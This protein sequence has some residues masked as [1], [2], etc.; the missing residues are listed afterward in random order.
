MANNRHPRRITPQV[1]MAAFD[2]DD[3]AAV[4]DDVRSE[5]LEA[6]VEADLD[7]AV[8]ALMVD[9][10]VVVFG[11]V[12]RTILSGPDLSLFLTAYYT[13]AAD[14]FQ[15]LGDF[16]ERFGT[17]V[18]AALKRDNCYIAALR[19]AHPGADHWRSFREPRP[20]ANELLAR[21]V[22]ASPTFL[23][24]GGAPAYMGHTSDN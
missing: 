5:V 4:P 8:A 20:S 14:P 12:G 15:S 19:D 17:E 22:G 7:A 16:V 11:W 6:A 9:G 10:R 23:P 3:L 24:S 2:R 21:C 1:V 18:P 13:D